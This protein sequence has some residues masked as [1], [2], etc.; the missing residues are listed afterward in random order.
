MRVGSGKQILDREISPPLEFWERERRVRFNRCIPYI[1]TQ[2][3]R[4]NGQC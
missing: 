3:F 4:G 1:H 2:L